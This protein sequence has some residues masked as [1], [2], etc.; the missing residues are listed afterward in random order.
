MPREKPL[1]LLKREL[2]IDRRLHDHGIPSIHTCET[3]TETRKA[4][5]RDAIKGRALEAVIGAAPGDPRGK[6]MTY[7]QAFEYVF[8]EPL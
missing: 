5:T 4:R 3:T 6:P 8:G 2:W 7:A 1:E